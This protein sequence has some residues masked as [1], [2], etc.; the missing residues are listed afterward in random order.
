M[1]NR[2]MNKDY[3]IHIHSV[4]LLRHKKEQRWATS[5][6]MVGPRPYHTETKKDKH[7]IP[8][9]IYGIFK[10]EIQMNLLTKQK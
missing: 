6:D 4:I 5:R 10:K 2:G 1:F 7:H 9:L 8:P 3:V